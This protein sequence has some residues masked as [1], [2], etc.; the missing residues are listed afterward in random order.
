MLVKNLYSNETF[1]VKEADEYVKMVSKKAMYYY[2]VNNKYIKYLELR[3][4]IKKEDIE[5]FYLYSYYEDEK[6]NIYD[7]TFTNNYNELKEY[8]QYFNKKKGYK[9]ISLF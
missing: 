9:Q 8:Y 4:D 5:V 3:E 6:G 2:E 1:E 7:G